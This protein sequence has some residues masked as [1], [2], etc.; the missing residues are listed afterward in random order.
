MVFKLGIRDGVGIRVWEWCKNVWYSNCFCMYYWFWSVWEWCKNVWYSN[1]YRISLTL[2]AVW[3]WCKN[4]WYSNLY[5]S[6]SF[7]PLFENDVKMYG[8]QTLASLSL[9]SY[10]FENDVKMYG[11]QTDPYPVM[12]KISLRMM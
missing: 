5:L 1:V 3:E 4:V 8:I 6:F 7:N 9:Y 11:I 2:V 12:L 10:T